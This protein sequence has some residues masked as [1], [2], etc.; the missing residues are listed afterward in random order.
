MALT[1]TYTHTHT[2]AGLPVNGKTNKVELLDGS[3]VRQPHDKRHE[4]RTNVGKC[5]SSISRP[6]RYDRHLPN[7]TSNMR[8][9]GNSVLLLFLFL[10]FKFFLERT[11]N[12]LHVSVDQWWLGTSK[13]Y[14]KGEKREQNRVAY[15]D[16]WN[17]PDGWTFFCGG[18]WKNK[19]GGN[20]ELFEMIFR[21]FNEI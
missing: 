8:G 5:Q 2:H 18:F 10:L 13:I 9:L 17:L 14:T 15:D 7:E 4:C 16:V 1:H 19:Q 21:F 6:K 20:H 12:P 3:F 11:E